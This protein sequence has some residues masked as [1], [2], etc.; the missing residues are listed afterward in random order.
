MMVAT[1]ALRCPGRTATPL[2]VG[3]GIAGLLFGSGLVSIWLESEEYGHGLV[4]VAALCFLVY[5]RRDELSWGSPGCW[6]LSA[7]LAVL[8]ALAVL[9]GA[10]TGISQLEQYGF[11]LFA[12]LLVYAWGGVALLRALL[13]PLLVLLLVIP[14]PYAIQVAL[15]AQLQLASSELGA[16]V[17]R[18]AGGVVFLQGNVIDMGKLTLLVDEACSGLRYLFPLMA[19]GAILAYV[20]AAPLWKQLLLVAAAV[21]VT[22]FMNGL[23]IAGTGLLVDRYGVAHSQGFLHAFEGWAVFIAALGLLGIIAVL[24]VRFGAGPVVVAAAAPAAPNPRARAVVAWVL[25]ASTAGAFVLHQR[26]ESV[27]PRRGFSEFPYALGDW[28]AQ[29]QPLPA[30]LARVAGASDYYHGELVAAVGAPVNLYIA[31]YASQRRGAVPHSPL[32]C[33]PGDGWTIR[34][35]SRMQLRDALGRPFQVNRVVSSK[36]RDTVLAYFWIKQGAQQYGNV[37]AARLGL[38]MSALGSGRTDGA[39]VR[40]VTSV[41]ADETADQ[42]DARLV[43]AASPLVTAMLPFVP[44]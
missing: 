12:A 15:T 21:P 9:V 43:A 38:L 27:P 32:V 1:G 23:R 44:D 7:A 33:L 18:A 34:S 39:L 35:V 31:Y 4:V 26:P 42:A 5:R 29:A 30:D 8:P 17:I 20:I 28:S 3:L 19:L 2:L 16:A 37:W 25:C 24:L 10:L 40:L 13:M 41:A 11:W 22:V 6:Q 14:V 36:G